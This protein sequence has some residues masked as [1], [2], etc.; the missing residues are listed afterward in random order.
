MAIPWSRGERK[1]VSSTRLRIAN[2]QMKAQLAALLTLIRRNDLKFKHDLSLFFS[3]SKGSGEPES[4]RKTHRTS[5]FPNSSTVLL[6]TSTAPCWVPRSA[7]IPRT[8]G[9]DFQKLHE[10]RNG[11]SRKGRR[12]TRGVNE[13]VFFPRASTSAFVSSKSFVEEP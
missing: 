5:I 7:L 8:P 4:N 10:V 11:V 3:F 9:I 6:T 2:L 1:I 13:L 12:G